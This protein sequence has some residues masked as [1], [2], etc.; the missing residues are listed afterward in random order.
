MGKQGILRFVPEEIRYERLEELYIKQQL[1]FSEICK[2]LG[3]GRTTLK[4]WINASGLDHRYKV[5][6]KFIKEYPEEDIVRDYFKLKS[7]EAIISERGVHKNKVSTILRNWG[8]TT[9]KDLGNIRRHVNGEYLINIDSE[10]EEILIGELLGDFSIESTSSKIEKGFVERYFHSIDFLNEYS[11]NNS[12]E[13]DEKEFKRYWTREEKEVHFV[14][15]FFP[16]NFLK[17]Q[18][19]KQ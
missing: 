16:G 4:N 14:E 15:N 1:S 6:S 11:T 18:R 19:E 3:I 2:T 10:L 13:L 12:K 7:I 8:I 5:D 9:Y 17:K